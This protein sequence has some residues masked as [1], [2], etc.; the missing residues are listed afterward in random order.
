MLTCYFRKAEKE[1]LN[2]EA[3]RAYFSFLFNLVFWNDL[4]SE[5]ASSKE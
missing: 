1:S 2:S 5:E 4:I 3:L